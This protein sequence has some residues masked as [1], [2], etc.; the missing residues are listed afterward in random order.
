MNPP[1]DYFHEKLLFGALSV[2][3]SSF[4]WMGAIMTTGESR[5]LYLTA[6][7][8][9]MMSGFLSLVFRRPDESIR[10]VI[11]RAGIATLGGIFGTKFVVH[12]YDLGIAIEDGINLAGIASLVCVTVFFVGIKALNILSTR[13]DS[14]LEK[15]LGALLPNNPKNDPPKDP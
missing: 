8:S 6:A 10:L 3:S 15:L 1:L 4:L 14:I 7:A 2:I 9:I 5:W 12:H 11:G 13:A